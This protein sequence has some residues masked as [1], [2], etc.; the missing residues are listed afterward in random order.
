MPKIAKKLKPIYEKSI[1]ATTPWS[2]TNFGQQSEIDIYIEATGK[3][4]TVADIHTV[5][6]IDAEDIASLIVHIVNNYK[7]TQ[8]LIQKMKATLELCLTAKELNEH[9][10]R[11][12]ESDLKELIV[13]K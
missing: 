8:R 6:D 13:N 4:E 11:Q 9:V 10:K 3:W 12:I 5:A 2:C 7:K 1:L